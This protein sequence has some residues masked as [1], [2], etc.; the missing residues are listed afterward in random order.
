MLRRAQQIVSIVI[1]AVFSFNV[2]GYYLLFHFLQSEA[3]GEFSA[4]RG[5]RIE[6]SMVTVAIGASAAH[7]LQWRSAM[8]FAYRGGVY[9]VVDSAR[10]ADTTYYRCVAD[11]REQALD[12][13]V[14]Q[15][16]DRHSADG[17]QSSEPLKISMKG[18]LG[19][20]EGLTML[21]VHALTAM[22]EAPRESAAH[23]LSRALAVPTPPPEDPTSI[24]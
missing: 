11:A 6:R 19:E 3:R 22:R 18:P 21:G 10:V 12:L 8:E 14:A 4:T 1:L 16:V 13:A 23:C 17:G 2:A 24:R 7:V 5:T 20:Y 9:D 15:H